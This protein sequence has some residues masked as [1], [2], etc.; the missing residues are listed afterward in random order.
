MSW[1]VLATCLAPAPV[2]AWTPVG[3]MATCEQPLRWALARDTHGLAE[4]FEPAV[5]ASLEAWGPVEGHCYRFEYLG[6][7]DPPTS[8]FLDDGISMISIVR[9]EPTMR[10][11]VVISTMSRMA[12]RGHYERLGMTLF[13][14]VENDI[15]LN[16]DM[17]LI[18]ASA[19]DGGCAGQVVVENL[20]GYELGRSLGLVEPCIEGRTC[21]PDAEETAMHWPLH[22][23]SVRAATPGP[24]ERQGLDALYG[25]GPS[26]PQ[27]VVPQPVPEGPMM[28]TATL[29]GSWNRLLLDEI[30]G[31]VPPAPEA[32]P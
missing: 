23:C 20:L 11:S 8:P 30:A 26:R 7:V 3:W 31:T 29:H 25:E 6:L 1:L 12:T 9:D 13:A 14:L 22:A 21:A 19:L 10:P 5:K 16:A 27:L 18:A 32:I 17:P 2:T 15:V 4:G 24:D 28:D